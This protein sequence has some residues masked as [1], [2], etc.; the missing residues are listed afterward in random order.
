MLICR[1][2]RGDVDMN[3]VDHFITLYRDLEEEN[4]MTPIIQHGNVTFAYVKHRDLFRILEQEAV[5]RHCG[6]DVPAPSLGLGNKGKH[7][8]RWRMKS[9]PP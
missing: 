6:C 4:K 1:N 5:Q 8:P 9:M 7:D 3:Y 2:Y